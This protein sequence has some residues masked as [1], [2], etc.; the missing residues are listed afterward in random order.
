MK[1]GIDVARMAAA[2]A[3]PLH[4]AIPRVL[5]DGWQYI[6]RFGDGSAYSY[7][8]GLRVIV[9]T[10]P[11]PDGRDW[12]HISVSRKDRIPSYDDLKFVKNTFAE[13]RFGYQVFPPPGDNVNIHDFCLHVWV[14]LTGEPPMPNFGEEG[15]I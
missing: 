11:F 13:K 8:N 12:M 4:E 6:Q 14:P 9:S 10:G 2:M 3:L 7:R 1:T 15:T 5:P